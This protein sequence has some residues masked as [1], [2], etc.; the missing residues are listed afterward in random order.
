MISLSG[1]LTPSGPT[2]AGNC[3]GLRILFV[4]TRPYLPA[5]GCSSF[6]TQFGKSEVGG[7]IMLSLGAADFQEFVELL[8]NGEGLSCCRQ[9]SRCN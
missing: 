4:H 1:M 8:W 7:P 2:I 9:E 5:F 3:A 6:Y